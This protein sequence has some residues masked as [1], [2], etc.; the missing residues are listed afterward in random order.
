[1][2]GQLWGLGFENERLNKA[3]DVREKGWRRHQKVV[4]TLHVGGEGFSRGVGK[5]LQ[6][7]V[8]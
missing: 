6:I 2:S 5:R 8:G 3:A 4:V 7:M 1:M